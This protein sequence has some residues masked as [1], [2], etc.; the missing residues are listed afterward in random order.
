[1]CKKMTGGYYRLYFQGQQVSGVNYI[2]G[3]RPFANVQEKD[4]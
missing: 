3:L 2:Y 4:R 1:M